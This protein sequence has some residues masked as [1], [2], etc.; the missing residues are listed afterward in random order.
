M[1]LTA[2]QQKQVESLVPYVKVMASRRCPGDEDA[3]SVATLALCRATV[4]Y[5]PG[6]GTTLKTYAIWYVR[7]RLTDY[8]RGK[9][10][11][12]AAEVQP[13][14][15]VHVPYEDKGFE[16]VDV[17]DL[18]SLL[19]K[20]DREM[21]RLRYLADFSYQRISNMF[22][23][24]RERVRQICNRCKARLRREIDGEPRSNTSRRL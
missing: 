17:E 12:R 11:T 18:L 6:K 22:G 5:K 14:S 7:G 21:F 23:L 2:E 24:S 4:L 13:P 20:R 8:I 1:K 15:I 16:R 9:H 19:P 10:Q 3:I